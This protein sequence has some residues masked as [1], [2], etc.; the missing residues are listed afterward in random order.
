MSALNDLIDA[1]VEAGFS[2]TNARELAP[3]LGGLGSAVIEGGVAKFTIEGQD[4]A[5]VPLDANGDFVANIA[6]RRGLFADLILLDGGNGEITFPTDVDG[7]ILHNG[8]PGGAKF[9]RRLDTDQTLGAQ[10]LAVGSGASTTAAAVGAVAIGNGAAAYV[11]GQISFGS[12]L[13][14]LKTSRF[15]AVAET[16]GTATSIFTSDG[17]GQMSGAII[18]PQAPGLYEL[19]ITVLAREGTTENFARMVRR[20]VLTVGADG[21]ATSIP[22]GS[23]ATPMADFLQNLSGIT[24]SLTGFPGRILYITATGQAGKT[25]KWSM[26]VDVVATTVA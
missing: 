21:V 4:F 20:C 7:F 8:V 22:A 24:L 3:K 11:S 17:S 23:I 16:V 9:Y 2:S 13:P 26:C 1:L 19:N 10:S 14:T 25:L 15:T 6:H 5:M 18:F 12:A